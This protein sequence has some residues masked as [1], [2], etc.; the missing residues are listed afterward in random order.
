MKPLKNTLSI[1]SALAVVASTQ[2]FAATQEFTP[3][4][5]VIGQLESEISARIGVAVF[6]TEENTVWSYKGNDRVPITSTFKTL[7]CAKLLNDADKGKIDLS[8]SVIIQNSMLQE[9]SP[10][11]KD[12]LGKR[13]FLHEACAATMHTSD[14]TAANIVLDAIGG[15]PELTKFIRSVGDEVSRLD[16]PEPELNEGKPGDVRDTTSPVAMVETI[17]ELLYGNTLSESRQLQLKDWMINNQVTGNLLRS[18]LPADWEIADRSGAGGYG[19]R[20][21][22]A[23][24]WSESH[25]PKIISIYIADTDASLQQRND[26][27]VKI[28][29]AIFNSYISQTEG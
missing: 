24:V 27:I 9:Y 16:R 28:G 2:I 20:S 25:A 10:I 6:D 17:N 7:A 8:D 23:A 12:Y 13:I 18:V 14:N 29:K 22:T 3:V 26:A 4:K 1:I 11:T 21:I 5:D 15:P 19:S